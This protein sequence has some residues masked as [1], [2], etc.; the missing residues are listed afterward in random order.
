MCCEGGKNA[1]K[2]KYLLW[3]G[4]ENPQGKHMCSWQCEGCYLRPRTLIVLVPI[5]V[6]WLMSRSR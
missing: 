3:L 2:R 5:V 6:C 1:N 4:L